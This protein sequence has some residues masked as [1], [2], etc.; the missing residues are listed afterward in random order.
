[1]PREKDIAKAIGERLR[2]LREL[3]GYSLYDVESFVG[4]PVSSLHQYEAGIAAVPGDALAMLC[5]LYSVSS[6]YVITGKNIP[7]EY[8]RRKWPE[9]FQVVHRA[10]MDLK[11]EEKEAFVELC[12]GALKSKARLSKLTW[13]K[14]EKALEQVDQEDEGESG[15]K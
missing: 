7:G 12:R 10:F 1:M 8:L 2:R 4:I 15:E 6:D 14:L 9:G 5:K 13:E 11:E 3:R